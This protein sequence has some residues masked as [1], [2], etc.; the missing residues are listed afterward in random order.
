MTKEDLGSKIYKFI[1][2]YNYHEYMSSTPINETEVDNIENIRKQ[3][4]TSEGVEDFIQYF[5][6]ILKCMYDKTKSQN[7]VKDFI[8]ELESLN[9]AL[10]KQNKEYDQEIEKE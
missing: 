8:N 3:L 9:K 6:E 4:L 10:K 7:D 5:K 2:S 1:K